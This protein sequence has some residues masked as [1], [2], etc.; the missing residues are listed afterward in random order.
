M[1]YTFG[2]Q[3][4]FYTLIML[5][6]RFV[7]PSK[8][9]PIIR[10][11]LMKTVS[12]YASLAGTAYPY[13]GEYYHEFGLLGVILFCFLLGLFCRYLAKKLYSSNI[14]DI[15]IYSVCFPLLFQ[16][17]IR[18]YTPSNFYMMVFVLLP[19]VFNKKMSNSYEKQQR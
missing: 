19:I 15:I 13:L 4:F 5:V 1:N 2:E 12:K 14:H 9:Q 6:P 10:E 17:L 7:W 18:G 11:V 8:P 16:I 3:M